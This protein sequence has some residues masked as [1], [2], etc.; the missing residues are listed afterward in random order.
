MKENFDL[1]DFK[2][3]SDNMDAISALDRGEGGRTGPNPDTFA[4]VAD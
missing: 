4:Y 3:D 2:L 1:F